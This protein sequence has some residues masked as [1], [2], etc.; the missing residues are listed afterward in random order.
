MTAGALALVLVLPACSKSRASTSDGVLDAGGWTPSSDPAVEALWARAMSDA[1]TGDDLARLADREGGGGLAGRGS[2]DPGA[3][4][5]A[6]RAMAFVPDPQA[7]EGLP[8]LADVARGSN[9]EEAIA[10]LDS[11]IDLAAHPRR[12]VDP[13]DAAEL[14]RGCDELLALAVDREAGAKNPK[15]LARRVKAIRALRMLVERGC[16]DPAAIPTD[17][18]AH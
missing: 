5:T 6:V 17:A 11:A 16:V 15:I 9:D 8:F 13:E 1:G 2:A 12:A 3:R 18:D 14:K 7:F 4:M 10:A